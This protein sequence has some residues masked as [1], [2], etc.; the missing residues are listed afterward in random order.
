LLELI[1]LAVFAFLMFFLTKTVI[2]VLLYLVVYRMIAITAYILLGG[3]INLDAPA[4]FIISRVIFFLLTLKIGNR[5]WQLAKRYKVVNVIV[6]IL[7]VW[8]I[9]SMIV[10]PPQHY[11]YDQTPDRNLINNYI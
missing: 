3:V 7:F 8:L 6:V 9:Y 11:Y 2:W 4:L 10:S 5:I 1:F